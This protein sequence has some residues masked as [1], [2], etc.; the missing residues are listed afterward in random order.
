MP[1]ACETG[2][3]RVG[4]LC[5]G[6]IV[7]GTE[8]V[9]LT[10]ARGLKARGH[11]VRALVN[12]WNNGDFTAR[13]SAAAIA[14]EPA[15]IGKI[16]LTLRQPYLGWSAAAIVRLPG[17]LLAARRWL[18]SF[19]PD[20]VI[21]N[22]RDSMLL[23]SFL[24]RDVPVLFH[25]HEAPPPTPVSTRVYRHIAKRTT[26]FIAVSHYVSTRLTELGI[27]RD[28]TQVVYNG[29]DWPASPLLQPPHGRPFTVGI[30]GRIGE[31]KGHEDLIAALGILR[32]RGVEVRCVVVGEGD[33]AYVGLLR[34][35][36]DIEGVADAVEWRGYVKD[37]SAVYHRFDV[38]AVPSRV[39][40][41]FGLVAV[42]AGLS[43][44]PV[45]AARVGG[46]PEIVRDGETGY[47]VP[48][49]DPNALAERLGELARDPARRRTFGLAAQSRLRGR[50]TAERMIAEIEAQCRQ[51][52][53]PSGSRGGASLACG[54]GSLVR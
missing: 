18:R 42:E 37:T 36:A 38:C 27:A 31:W 29:V 30:V 52:V 21:A 17:A 22:N 10:V 49:A 23:L 14:Y 7:S 32:R 46:L 26:T 13:L 45:V 54:F 15:Y 6:T 1:S 41:A 24:L 12:G 50:F 5:S 9:A 25:M 43:G 4:I 48:P 33:R 2:P 35:L 8:M 19:Q 40:E 47:L 39:S 44:V 11:D 34:E 20:V 53:T 51:A 16:S 3:L 28:K